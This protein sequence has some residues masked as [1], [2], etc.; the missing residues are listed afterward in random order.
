MS[1]AERSCDVSDVDDGFEFAQQDSVIVWEPG[2][3]GLLLKGGREFY[4]V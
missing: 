2:V 4:A 3:A 1:A